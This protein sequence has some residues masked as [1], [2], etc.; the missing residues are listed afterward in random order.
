MFTIGVC[1]QTGAPISLKTLISMCQEIVIYNLKQFGLFSHVL[2]QARQLYTITFPCRYPA[3]C[4]SQIFTHY[5]S[6]C[7]SV[8]RVVGGSSGDVEQRSAAGF[9]GVGQSRPVCF[10]RLHAKED[11]QRVQIWPTPV[12]HQYSC[13]FTGITHT[14]D[15]TG[16]YGTNLHCFSPMNLFFSF[17]FSR[18]CLLN[19][20]IRWVC[21]MNKPICFCSNKGNFKEL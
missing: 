7:R 20:S 11:L 3:L 4:S 21:V 8:G 16:T 6:P 10:Q 1:S 18:K 9:A 14:N 19:R 2:V 17:L 15:D 12:R 13:C 5:F